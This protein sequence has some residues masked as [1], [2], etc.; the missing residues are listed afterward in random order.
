MMT[1]YLSILL[2]LC[3]YTSYLHF[4]LTHLTCTY[5][6]VGLVT[7]GI[8]SLESFTVSAD[9]SKIAFAGN[10]GYIHICSGKQRTWSMDVKMNTSVR[11]LEFVNETSLVTSGLDADVYLWDLR[12]NGRCVRRYV[13]KKTR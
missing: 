10:G 2:V 4:V 1:L 13:Q 11:A 6:S 9:G 12:Y 7:K 8:K 5:L 3:P